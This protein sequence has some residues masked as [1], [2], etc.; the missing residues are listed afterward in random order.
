MLL[1][2][3][4]SHLHD[5]FSRETTLREILEEVQVSTDD[6][7][8]DFYRRPIASERAA[9]ATLRNEGSCE[10]PLIVAPFRVSARSGL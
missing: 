10:H 1:A 9:L 8:H 4:F 7:E 3:P 5:R 6:T 2:V